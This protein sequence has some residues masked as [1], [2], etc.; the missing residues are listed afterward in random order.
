MDCSFSRTS[1]VEV[2]HG[3]FFS[4]FCDSSQSY[5]VVSND[6]YSVFNGPYSL[7]L[8]YKIMVSS[9]EYFNSL[10]SKGD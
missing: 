1:S 4:V 2:L 7:H 9:N 8:A 5:W 6:F 10:N 3:D